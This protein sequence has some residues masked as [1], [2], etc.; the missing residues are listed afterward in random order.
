[1][2]I[3]TMRILMRILT[4]GSHYGLSLNT[5]SGSRHGPSR[6]GPSR[7]ATSGQSGSVVTRMV[8]WWW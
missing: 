2:R 8:A 7:Q 3:L 5:T 1:M 6:H 4:M